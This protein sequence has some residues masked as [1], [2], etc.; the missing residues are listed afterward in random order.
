MGGTV[1]ARTVDTVLGRNVNIRVGRVAGGRGA[2]SRHSGRSGV[3]EP[4]SG[5]EVVARV[6]RNGGGKYSSKT[7]YHLEPSNPYHHIRNTDN[8]RLVLWEKT[9]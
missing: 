8:M 7:R 1:A 9:R 3:M 5:Q 6:R 4:Q 2:D